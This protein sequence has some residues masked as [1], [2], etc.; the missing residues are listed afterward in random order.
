MRLN[1]IILW[2]LVL[3]LLTMTIGNIYF[4]NYNFKLIKL[5]QETIE[6]ILELGDKD[7]GRENKNNIENGLRFLFIR[8]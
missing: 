7:F 5:Q 8:D 2:I 4:T 3:I 6:Y 1:E